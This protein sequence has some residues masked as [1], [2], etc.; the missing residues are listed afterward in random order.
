[1]RDGIFG[2][3]VRWRREKVHGPATEIQTGMKSV[4]VGLHPGRGVVAG[5]A[6]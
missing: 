5:L 6:G 3:A 4:D 2:S 1:M